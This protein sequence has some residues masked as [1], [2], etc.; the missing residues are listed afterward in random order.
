MALEDAL[1]LSKQL[2][3]RVCVEDALRQYERIRQPRTRRMAKRSRLMCSISAWQGPAITAVRDAIM[4]A[5]PRRFYRRD[6]Q[7]QLGG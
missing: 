3:S 2:T 5:V 1:A 7:W 6:S 4:K